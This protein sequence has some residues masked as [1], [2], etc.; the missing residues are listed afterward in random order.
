MALEYD[1]IIVNGVVVTDTSIQNLDIAIKDEK[2]AKI[3]PRGSLRDVQATRAIDAEGGY[4][5]VG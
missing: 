1:L 3:V 2:I 5:M 4:V